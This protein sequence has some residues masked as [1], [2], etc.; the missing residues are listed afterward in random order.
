MRP[1]TPLPP[2][3]ANTTFRYSDA[4]ESGITRGQVRA[5]TTTGP[6]RGIRTTREITSPRDADLAYARASPRDVAL[7]S[8][9]ACRV[10]GIPLPLAIESRRH[11]F[12]AVRSPRHV[13]TGVAITGIRLA[14]HLFSDREFEGVRLLSPCVAWAQLSAQ[15]TPRETLVQADALLTSADNYPGRR[16]GGSLATLDELRAVADA[17]AKRA[18]VAQLRAAVELARPQVES[19]GESR[20]R[21]ALISARFPEPVL[22]HRVFDGR[23][24]VARIDLAYPSLKIALEYDGENHFTVAKA[25]EDIERRRELESLGWRVIQIT[26]RDIQDP[27]RL[28]ARLRAAMRPR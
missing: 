20:L 14:P 10:W 1:K 13:P 24:F 6:H 5:S 25:V 8:V 9:S 18:G 19:P 12:V 22:Q 28:F 21:H 23:R 16:H 7:A 15:I 26:R 27:T 3:F 17:W 11:T 2:E 4:L